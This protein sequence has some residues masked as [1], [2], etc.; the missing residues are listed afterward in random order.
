MSD[1]AQARLEWR[2]NNV[3]GAERLLNQC[4]PGRRGWEWHYL[5]GVNQP[6]L[7]TLNCPDIS[8]MFGVAFSRDGR[9]LA[10]S[11]WDYYG[12][13]KSE[14]PTPVAIWDLQEGRLLHTLKG[15]GVGLRPVFSPDGRIMAT[16][17]SWH[18]VQLWDVATGKPMAA[19]PEK[20][21]ASF[22]PDGRLLAVGDSEAITIRGEVVTG[23]LVRRI[24]SRGGRVCF[25]PDDQILASSARDGVELRSAL[26]GKEIG[27]LPHGP[28]DQADLY[29]PELGPELAFSP[30]SKLL[31][32]A[33][34]PPRLWDV[35]AKR[36]IATLGGHA[37]IVP[38]V[39]FSP[40][41]RRIATAGADATIRLW[42]GR[43]GSE[44]AVL[45]G[46]T[47]MA[48]CVAFHPDGHT[49]ASGGRQPGDVKLW[50]LTRHTEFLTFNAGGPQALAF[51]PGGQLK[52]LSIRGRVQTLNPT[53]GHNDEGPR[54]DLMQKWVSPAVLGA[55]SSDGQF[56]ASVS[57]DRRTVKVFESRSGRELAALIGHDEVPVQVAVSQDGLRV[58]A[59]ERAH[60]PGARRSLRVWEAA[61]GKSLAHYRLAQ[62]RVPRWHGAV[63]IS[64]DGRQVAF[65]DYK[66]G[67]SPGNDENA[68]AI[69]RVSDASGEQERF[70]VAAGEGG[71]A[72][73]AFSPDGRLLAAGGSNGRVMVWETATGRR[74]FIDWLELAP[75]GLAFDPGGTRLAAAGRESVT[76]WDIKSGKGVLTLR[77]APPRPTDF[78]TNAAVAWSHDGRWLAASNWDGSVGI[79]DG[80]FAGR[81]ARP[82]TVRQVPEARVYSWHLDQAEA[83]LNAGQPFAAAFHL[84]RVSVADPP[85]LTSRRRRGRLDLR[86][87]NTKLAAADLAAVFAA[88]E[89][90]DASVW[91]DYARV[92]VLQNDLAGYRRLIPRMLSHCGTDNEIT[93][94]ER[95][96]IHA[97][98]LADGALGD[99][100]EAV[101]HA[102]HF[103]TTR[104]DHKAP[105]LLAL[106]L[107]YHRA[108]LWQKAVDRATEFNAK[109]P[110]APWLGWPV[111]ALAHA[112]LGHHDEAQAWFQKAD[113]WASHEGRESIDAALGFRHPEWADFEILRRE[114]AE[115]ISRSAP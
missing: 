91:L 106:A 27:R 35:A 61:T 76:I 90:D 48:A 72:S 42:D 78:G 16:C 89:P 3:A 18:S 49:L 12:N 81:P 45:R 66:P 67:N 50:D 14:K 96:E 40:D 54:I 84:N 100:T 80:N 68:Q 83:A 85:D 57:G 1:I 17:G 19:L 21:L 107:V 93:S 31:V 75:L 74:R 70:T 5:R 88:T 33:T 113:E 102:E 22:S 24:P 64:P 55:F 52:A 115:S 29:F 73:L 13:S 108:G 104:R 114:A 69:V 10:F 30:D 41:G 60:G 79:W 103:A 109:N 97:S 47:G 37:G 112:A 101:R 6:E 25:S 28:G 32:T 82:A 44:L 43:T 26:S 11:G 23:K 39:A 95:E 111:L 99:P 38:G 87:G 59:T 62:P 71:I 58:A 2:L 9:F 53:T 56:V 92:L 4:D 51:E 110:A 86:R 63:A 8:M 105:D 7:A 36:P 98:V 94:P 46:H 15:A 77:A 34:S 65:D 20:G